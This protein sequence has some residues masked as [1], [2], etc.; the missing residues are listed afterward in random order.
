MILKSWG[1]YVKILFMNHTFDHWYIYYVDSKQFHI[2]SY[3]L[4][5]FLNT[6]R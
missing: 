5:N 4:T 6:N 1:I 3:Q 2:V